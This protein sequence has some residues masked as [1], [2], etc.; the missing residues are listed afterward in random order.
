[1]KLPEHAEEKGSLHMNEASFICGNEIN[2]LYAA[3]ISRGKMPWLTIKTLG[4][5]P[6]VNL[7]V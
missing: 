7:L 4:L 3:A 2:Q 5:V 1:M 6:V